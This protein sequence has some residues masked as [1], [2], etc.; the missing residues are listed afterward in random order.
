MKLSVTLLAPFLAGTFYCHIAHA[1]AA[2]YG[3]LFAPNADT[4]PAQTIAV[5]P[6]KVDET[7]AKMRA[8]IAPATFEDHENELRAKALA[9]Q[10]QKEQAE[11]SAQAEKAAQ[12][13]RPT[14]IVLQQPQPEPTFASTIFS[15]PGVLLRSLVR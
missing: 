4:K 8:A 11:K 6:P 10:A 15:L 3:Q 12:A 13:N 5:V 2:Q 7:Q 1:Q 14:V 9:L